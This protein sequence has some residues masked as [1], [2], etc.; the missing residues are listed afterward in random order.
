MYLGNL[1]KDT[2]ERFLRK[3][4]LNAKSMRKNT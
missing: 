4:T 3:I 2:N 1:Q